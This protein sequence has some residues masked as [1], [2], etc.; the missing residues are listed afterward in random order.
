VISDKDFAR[1]AAFTPHLRQNFV[2]PA[3][4]PFMIEA[5]PR[6]L[7]APGVGGQVGSVSYRFNAAASAVT[8]V[9]SNRINF[10]FIIARARFVCQIGFAGDV[11]IGFVVSRDNDLNGGLAVTGTNILEPL[12]N[13]AFPRYD[14]TQFIDE[15]LPNFHWLEPNCFIKCV[16]DNANAGSSRIWAA[17][18]LLPLTA[19]GW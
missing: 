13:E 10:P 9:A 12:T 7:A 17:L 1:S 19:T 4:P 8:I 2:K 5:R 15:V 11:R 18:D 3:P 6:A 16:L 14:V